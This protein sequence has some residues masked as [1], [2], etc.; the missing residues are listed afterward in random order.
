MTAINVNDFFKRAPDA[1]IQEKIGTAGKGNIDKTGFFYHVITKSYDGGNIYFKD[2]GEYRHTL[3]CKLCEDRGITIIFSVTMPNHTHDLFLTPSW[4]LLNDVFRSLNLN[5][6]KVFHR[7][8]PRKY[9]SNSFRIIKRHPT[10]IVIRDIKTL[11]Y[12]GKYIHDNPLYLEKEGKKTPYSCF[13]MFTSGHFVS[14]YDET[15][16]QKLFGLAPAEIKELYSTLSKDEI[17]KYAAAHFD[18]WTPEKTRA[19]FFKQ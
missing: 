8:Y 15:I 7:C 19:V 18:D 16:Y 10:Y 1:S 14:A 11:F 13:W 3:L 4:E 9:G 12:V 6:T 5:V 17:R 2:T